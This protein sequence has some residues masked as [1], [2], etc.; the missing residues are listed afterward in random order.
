[1]TRLIP[2]AVALYLS[3][4]AADAIRLGYADWLAARDPAAASRVAPQNAAYRLAAALAGGGDPQ[5]GIKAAIRLSPR[6]AL[7]RIRSGLAAEEAGDPRAAERALLEAARL[8]RKYEPRWTLAGFYYRQNKID[9]F[10][11]WGRE[12]LRM[13]Y[14]DPRPLFDLAWAAGKDGAAIRQRLDVEARTETWR[15]WIRHAASTGRLEEVEAVLD[16]VAP[17]P[18]I[19]EALLAGKRVKALAR[20]GGHRELDWRAVPREG[21]TFTAQASGRGFTVAF[22]GRQ[23]EQCDVAARISLGRREWPVTGDVR[24]LTWH[25]EPF[26]SEGLWVTLRYARPAGETRAVGVAR[27]TE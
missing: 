20:L 14:R 24:G 10:W 18:E 4:Q 22:D 9:D 8:S 12:A 2:F 15:A 27:V 19:V 13:S 1:M 25:A 26:G 17:E 6:D 23:P 16:R 7:L 5:P 11:R 3:L 21:V